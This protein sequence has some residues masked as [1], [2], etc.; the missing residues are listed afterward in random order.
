MYLYVLSF[1]VQIK[2]HIVLKV[3]ELAVY[4]KLYIEYLNC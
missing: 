1:F 3:L 2:N 4:L